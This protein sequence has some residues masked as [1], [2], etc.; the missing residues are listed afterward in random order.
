MET[1]FTRCSQSRCA[2]TAAKPCLSHVLTAKIS[3]ICVC[4]VSIDVLSR[5]SPLTPCTKPVNSKSAH[6]PDSR[7]T[8]F[9][10]AC[11]LR[12]C[13]V[14]LALWKLSALLLAHLMLTPGQAGPALCEAAQF[15][16]PCTNPT[17]KPR[18][19]S[20]TWPRQLTAA[21]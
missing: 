17:P 7:D 8:R 3:Q 6:V 19:H 10:A 2:L 20:S 1:S 11:A 16:L 12:S 15:P 13:C 4:M 14:S 21:H 5:I 18:T 9:S